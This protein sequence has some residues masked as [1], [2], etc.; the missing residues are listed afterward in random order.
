MPATP[1]TGLTPAHRTT[2]RRLYYPY[3]QTFMIDRTRA[4]LRK[5]RPSLAAAGVLGLLS[6]LGDWIWENFIPDGAMLPGVIH[7]VLIFL[8]L[9][10]VL[11]LAAKSRTALRRLLV[12]LPIAGLLLAAAFYPLAHVLG[13]LGALV[14]TWITMWLTLA[15]LQ[16]WAREDTEAVQR[17]LL[18]GL[19]A[20]VASGLAFWAISGIWTNPA[21]HD[22]YP[23]RIV[24]WTFAFFPGFLALLWGQPAARTT[25]KKEE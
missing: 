20:G 4:F 15:L 8:I 22:S 19:L 25:G 7:G 10:L 11:G 9:A 12:S 14:A 18:R 13:Y 17:A 5:L 1:H 23:L 21:L 6:T 16:H 2:N 24:Y 3:T